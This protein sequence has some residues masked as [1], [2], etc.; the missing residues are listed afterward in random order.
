MRMNVVPHPMLDALSS[1]IAAR[2][3]Q[4]SVKLGIVDALEGG[5]QSLSAIAQQTGL[6]ERGVTLT[7]DCLDALGYVQRQNGTCA[8]TSR[9]HK[10]LT[11]GSEAGFRNMVLYA[12]HLYHTF[13]HLESSLAVE[14]PTP[15]SLQDYDDETWGIFCRAMLELARMSVVQVTTKIPL[16]PGAV[17]LL[18]LGGCHGLYSAH[19]CQRAAGLSAEIL[20]LQPTESYAH[21]TI[22][23]YG[24]QDRIRFRAGDFFA[25]DLGSSYDVVLGFNITHMSDADQN[26]AL[27]RKVYHCLNPGGIYVIM[28]QIQEM[29]GRSQ[30]ARFVTSALALNLYHQA[31]GRCYAYR[32]IR[33]WLRAAGYERSRLLKL[34]AA[35]S[36]LVVAWK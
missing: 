18:D 32:E 12:T 16:P 10:F 6:S 24:L 13:D 25:D 5:P 30:L 34:R 11:K 21:S 14:R 15:A 1:V 9:G 8:L 17:R 23:Q 22:Q 27:A 28:D 31:G 36:G 29:G 2:A 7:V 33:E 3:L 35:G 26:T 4:A 19:L 20:D